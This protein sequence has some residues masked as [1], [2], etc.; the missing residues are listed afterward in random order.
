MIMFV[1]AYSHR[2]KIR[3]NKALLWILA[4]YI[5]F[6]TACG[7]THFFDALMFYKPVYVANG[8]VRLFTAIFSAVTAISLVKVIPISL[9]IPIVLLEQKTLIRKQREWLRDTLDAIT[10]G[11]LTF[12]DDAKSFPTLQ[13]PPTDTLHLD[14]PSKLSTIRKMV[15]KCADLAGLPLVRKED[16]VAAV[17]ECAM[18]AL[19]HAGSGTVSCYVEPGALRILVADNGPGMDIDKLPLATLK[20]GYSTMGTAGQGWNIIIKIA[21]KV[22]LDT[23]PGKTNILID[24]GAEANTGNFVSDVLD[25]DS[26]PSL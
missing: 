10:E 23:A 18:N 22:H 7:W 1:T 14:H 15:E 16:A 13:E 26:F 17:H 9:R 21:N 24:V 11:V 12:A 6:I 19:R 4:L 8:Y 3:E 5:V 2:Q 25:L 20:R